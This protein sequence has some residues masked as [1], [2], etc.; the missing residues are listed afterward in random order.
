M[1]KQ[2][3][4]GDRYCDL[5]VLEGWAGDDGH[6]GGS[7]N[8]PTLL[9]CVL[10][11][12]LPEPGPLGLSHPGTSPSVAGSREVLLCFSHIWLITEAAY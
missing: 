12:P 7:W 5:I 4:S 8:H 3:L 9:P 10:L 2:W 6:L 1:S 11:C